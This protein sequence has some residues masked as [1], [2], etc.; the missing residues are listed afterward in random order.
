MS[1]KTVQKSSHYFPGNSGGDDKLSR[2]ISLKLCARPGSYEAVDHRTGTF[3]L[4]SVLTR[5]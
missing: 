3:L 1:T 5:A 4:W 2:L